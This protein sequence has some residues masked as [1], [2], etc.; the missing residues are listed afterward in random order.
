M[1]NNL[2]GFSHKY[3]YLAGEIVT[4]AVESS[5]GETAKSSSVPESFVKQVGWQQSGL[6]YPILLSIGAAYS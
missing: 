1:L 2:E 3:S 4:K 6:A 5:T